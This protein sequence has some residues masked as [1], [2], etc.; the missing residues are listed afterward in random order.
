[1]HFGGGWGSYQDP[2]ASFRSSHPSPSFQQH[3]T[4]DKRHAYHRLRKEEDVMR[5]F[6]MLFAW[7]LSLW[8]IPYKRISV[9]NHNSTIRWKLFSVCSQQVLGLADSMG[10]KQTGIAWP[11]GSKPGS[12]F[13]TAAWQGW[14]SEDLHLIQCRVQINTVKILLKLTLNLHL[15]HWHTMKCIPTD[16]ILVQNTNTVDN[17]QTQ[18][19]N[20][21]SLFLMAILK[22]TPAFANFT[23]ICYVIN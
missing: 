23:S 9:S 18:E 17:R 7:K 5:W 13:P 11:W 6:I 19:F 8:I 16:N 14:K 21:H 15:C 3:F 4:H 2:P 1:M 20:F 22:S 10:W 12:K